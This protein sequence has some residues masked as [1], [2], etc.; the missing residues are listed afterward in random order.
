[1]ANTSVAIRFSVEDADKA[2]AAFDKLAASGEAATQRL[3]AA[4][5][6]LAASYAA[7][8][9]KVSEAKAANDNTS[10]SYVDA[11]NRV[12]EFSGSI[13][14]TV[15]NVLNTVNHLKL[16]AVAAYALSPAFRSVV[17]SGISASFR[18][19]PTVAG[20]A[21]TAIAR[22]T[23]V[24]SPLLS[25]FSRI[26]LPIGAAVLGFEAFNYTLNQ[27]AEI[28]QKYAGY[29]RSL[30]G[31]AV[32]EN[33][34][35]LTKFQPNETLTTSQVQE[36]IEL[37][38]RLAEAKKNISDF[39]RV[40][41]DV[42]DPALRLQSI[43]VGI[44]GLIGD[45]AKK[46][47]DLSMPGTGGLSDFGNSAFF[48]ALNDWS[49]AHG[50]D[51]QL[52]GTLTP[53]D[54]VLKGNRLTDTNY[55]AMK[56]ARALLSVGMGGS[57]AGR[58]TDDINALANKD[59]P[60]APEKLNA[61]DRLIEKIKNEIEELNLQAE[62][63][64][65]SSAAFNELKVA[66]E[67]T[68]AAQKAGIPITAQMR[69]E[70]KDLGD[71][72]SEATIKLKQAQGL[73]SQQ[74]AT[75]TMFMSPADKAAANA[76]H[77]IDPN[78]W[79]SHI[80]DASAEQAA[81]NANLS[82]AHDLAVQFGDSLALSALKGK[83][84]IDILR[85]GVDLLMTSFLKFGVNGIVNSLFSMGAAG[86]PS[87]SMFGSLFKMFGF[88]D[89]GIMTAAGPIPLR[90]YAGG[91]VASGPQFALF[92]EGSHNEAYVPLPDGRAIPVSI[93]LRGA[94]SAPSVNSVM[95]LHVTVPPGAT[96]DDA[97]RMAS[98]FARNA[99]DMVNQAVDA[100]IIQHLRTGG[101]LNPV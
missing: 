81:F 29:E 66:H 76:A 25:F 94:P 86:G 57:F 16:L 18:E 69:K 100:R 92:G 41:I 63:A 39:M 22:I 87:G 93:N 2:N 38:N 68:L 47:N 11:A 51:A 21:S 28:L 89:G 17:N 49:K 82:Q 12:Q 52:P 42:S 19:I 1:M 91:G 34:K 98:S 8:D 48:K 36:A 55:D 73:Q 72:V 3:I 77:S 96:P 101:L 61:Y 10:S 5:N 45:A 85:Q 50:L 71:A 88:A 54:G 32:D 46:L 30:F 4:N 83:N 53:T 56:R 35:K 65:K 74:F 6:Q 13:A 31:P 67:A 23:P 58:F 79:K 9:G 33:L 97:E 84:G 26:T 62:G 20:L 15:E 37:S 27:G 70:W 99:K 14:G 90:R 7:L 44:V 75:D 64:N 95:N 24:L 43:W 40:Q 80:H 59:T 78:D 60:A